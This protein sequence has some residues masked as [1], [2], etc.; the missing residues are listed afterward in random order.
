MSGPREHEPTGRSAEPSSPSTEDLVPLVYDELRQIAA[1]SMRAERSNHTWQPTALVHEAYLRLA[2]ANDGCWASRDQFFAAAAN[3]IRQ[4]LVQHAR[5]RKRLKRGGG[6]RRIPIETA[7][8]QGQ[9][10]DDELLALDE[11]MRELGGENPAWERIVELRFFGGLPMNRVAEILGVS[12]RTVARR[13]RLARAW[14]K[15]RLEPASAR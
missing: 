8:D 1:R 2:G 13:W 14:L 10:T 4:L 15:L 6:W 3:L 11:A 5:R 12:P 7:L 9:T